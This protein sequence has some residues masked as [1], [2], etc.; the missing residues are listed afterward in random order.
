MAQC[1]GWVGGR[2]RLPEHFAARR[3]AAA[4][5]GQRAQTRCALRL[6]VRVIVVVRVCVLG[7]RQGVRRVRVLLQRLGRA[8]RQRGK[9][10]KTRDNGMRGIWTMSVVDMKAFEMMNAQ[11]MIMTTDADGQTRD[12]KKWQHGRIQKEKR[13]SCSKRSRRK[14]HM[15][16]TIQK[17]RGI[18]CSFGNDPEK[19]QMRPAPTP[20]THHLLH[21][22]R[23]VAVL[24]LRDQLQLLLDREL[25]R[26]RGQRLAAPG[27]LRQLG[28]REGRRVEVDLR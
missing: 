6:L 15:L 14:R 12:S 20:E 3:Q 19:K 23:R 4:G 27:G 7:V 21:L 22:R 8:D 28:R 1:G 9:R 18:E 10:E 5:L 2:W 16:Q 17:K 11:C 26:I 25:V 13:N 24:G